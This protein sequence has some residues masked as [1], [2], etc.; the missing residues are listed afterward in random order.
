MKV[1]L[2]DLDGVLCDFNRGYQRRLAQIAARMPMPS[3][4][5]PTC[6]NYAGTLGYTT[7]E[8]RATWKSIREDGLFWYGLRPLP[9]APAFLSRLQQRSRRV[10]EI[11]F[12]TT[13]VG[14][15]AK[16][17]SEQWLGEQGYPNPTVIVTKGDYK[18]EVAKALKATHAIDDKPENCFAIKAARPDCDVAL[19][20][21][22]YNQPFHEEAAALGVRIVHSPLQ[23]LDTL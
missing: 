12:V 7:D 20:S 13:R 9:E 3:Y 1:I 14:M 19:L 11:Y 18:G 5:E 8:D 10:E 2:I 23:F 17:Q 21:A 4:V 22:L 6:W 16:H 15:T